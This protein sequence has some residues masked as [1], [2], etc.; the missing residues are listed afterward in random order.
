VRGGNKDEESHGLNT[1]ETQR[2]EQFV[3]S[4]GSCPAILSVFN[5]CFIRGFKSAVLVQ[6]EEFCS[7]SRGGGL[8]AIAGS[9]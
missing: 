6:L 3:L 7:A 9:A 4:F 1:D 2:R 5:P 8:D